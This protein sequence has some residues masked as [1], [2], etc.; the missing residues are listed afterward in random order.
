MNATASGKDEMPQKPDS[1]N[2]AERESRRILDRVAQESETIG[3]SSMRRVADQVKGHMQAK[4]EDAEDWAELWG[5]RIGRGLGLVF[6]I[7]LVFYLALTYVF[8]V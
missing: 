8:K 2:D 5:T 7:V 3:A 1:D 4:D 6:V